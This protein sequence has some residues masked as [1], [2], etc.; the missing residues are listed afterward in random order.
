MKRWVSGLRWGGFAVSLTAMVGMGA[1]GESTITETATRELKASGKFQTTEVG[2]DLGYNIQGD[3]RVTVNHASNWTRVVVRVSGLPG[4]QVLYPA[5]VQDETCAAGGGARYLKNPVM[6]PAED[7]EIWPT[8]FADRGRG[9]GKAFVEDHVLR[10]D[11]RAVV[12]YDPATGARIA[13]A[14]VKVDGA[15]GHFE[16]L[17]AGKEREVEIEG[18]ALL[19]AF[20][21]ETHTWVHIFGGLRPGA[22]YPCHVHA[23]SCAQG[24]G[25]YLRDPHGSPGP[26]NEIWPTV[27]GD[28][29][30][31]SFYHLKTEHHKVRLE[32]Q[33]I[34]IHDPVDG[35][36]LACA[37]LK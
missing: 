1:C 18:R 20:R 34:V 19:R 5:H 31:H 28:R 22:A 9:K 23:G 14:D 24:R 3:V 26:D 32:A 8:I 16:L 27:R 36:R 21:S 33:S 7:N 35:A 12:L 2:R 17:A 15:F 29:R 13:C 4:H 11:G 6:S 30:G 10:P 37:D 25:H